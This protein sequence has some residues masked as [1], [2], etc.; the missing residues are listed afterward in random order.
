M[1]RKLF[2]LLFA[3]AA[4]ALLSAGCARAFRDDPLLLGFRASENEQWDDAVLRW[5]TAVELSPRSVSARNNLAVAYEKKGRW[6][7]ARK[8]YEKALEIDPSN[9]YVKYNFERFQENLDAWKG[10]DEKK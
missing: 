7:D 2:V 8:Q 1:K 3:A 4:A 9:T 5:E 6:E 10:A